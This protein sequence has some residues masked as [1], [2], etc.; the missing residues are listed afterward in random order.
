MSFFGKRNQPSS[1]CVTTMFVL[2]KPKSKTSVKRCGLEARVHWVRSSIYCCRSS[3]PRKGGPHQVFTRQNW[4]ASSIL[5][6]RTYCWIATIELMG[7]ERGAPF[8]AMPLVTEHVKAV[9][10][11]IQRKEA[12]LLSATHNMQSV[13]VGNGPLSKCLHVT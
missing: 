4:A 13:V 11:S 8:L 3:N 10:N 1:F 5:T 6:A 9:S 7:R 2:T 12:L